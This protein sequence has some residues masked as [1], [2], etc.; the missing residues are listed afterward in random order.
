MRLNWVAVMDHTRHDRAIEPAK[1]ATRCI[2]AGEVHEFINVGPSPRYP[3]DH[4]EYYGF[5]AF[6]TSG[7]LA[8][9]DALV[10]DGR[11]LGTISGF[12]ETHMPN[13]YNIL[14][15]GAHL[16]NGHT[17]GLTAGTPVFTRPREGQEPRDLNA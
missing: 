10:C 6:E 5:A 14:V 9:G 7:V 17:L 16:R 3:V 13:H 11:N 2:S 12:D 4:V 1:W 8:V 15:E